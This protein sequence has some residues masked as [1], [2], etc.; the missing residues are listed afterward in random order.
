VGDGTNLRLWH[1][2]WCGD[3]PPKESFPEL[4]S[5]ACCK[6][7]WVLNNMR[8]SNGNLHWNLSFIRSVQDWEVDLVIAF[9][10][11][12]YSLI[13]RQGGEDRIWWIPSKRRKFKIRSFYQELSRSGVHLFLGRVFAEYMF[14]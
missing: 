14:L 11:L 13:L 5:I 8:V 12:L 9:Y 4:F 2:L 3:H 10:D 1:D 6:E 7:A